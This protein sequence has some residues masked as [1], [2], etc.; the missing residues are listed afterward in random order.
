MAE[1][2]DHDSEQQARGQLASIVD[3]VA[4][5][6]CDYDRLQ[7]LRDDRDGF[8]PEDGGP[9]T[10]AEANPDDAEELAELEGAAGDCESQEQARERIE[11]DPLSV[12]VRSDW[13]APGEDPTDAGGQYEILLCTGGPACRIVGDLDDCCEPQMARIEH[14][15]WGTPWTE[16]FPDADGRAALLAYARC[17]CFGS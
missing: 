15:D 3:M 7:E 2:R 8:E 17:F 14:Q 1:T 13:H 12:Q 10:W 9:P 5:L 4:A 6:E 11:E 16:H